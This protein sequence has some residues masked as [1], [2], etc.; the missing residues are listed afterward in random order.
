M[1]SIEAF[2]EDCLLYDPESAAQDNENREITRM[3][4]ADIRVDMEDKGPEELSPS[5]N[6]GFAKTTRPIL[7]INY[8]LKRPDLIVLIINHNP[9]KLAAANKELLRKDSSGV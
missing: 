3:L 6:Q 4:L 5:Q 1:A 2:I 9:K 8:P 7:R